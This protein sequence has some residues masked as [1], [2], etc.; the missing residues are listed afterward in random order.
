MLSTRLHP[1][2]SHSG[3]TGSNSPQGACS[4]ISISSDNDGEPAGPES[5]SLSP[6]L[7]FLRHPG[8]SLGLSAQGRSPGKLCFLITTGMAASPQC[9]EPDAEG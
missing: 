1:I 8:H 7:K 4:P 5:S 9:N 3:P 2:S 6:D